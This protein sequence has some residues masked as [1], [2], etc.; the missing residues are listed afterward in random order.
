MEATG[1]GEPAAEYAAGGFIAR[2]NSTNMSRC[3]AQNLKDVTADN[4]QGYAGGFV[5]ISHTGDLAELAT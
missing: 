2:S 4:V 1:S 5:G 3:H